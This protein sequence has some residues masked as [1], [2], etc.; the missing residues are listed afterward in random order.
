MEHYRHVTNSNKERPFVFEQ[1]DVSD[2]ST[3]RYASN[4]RDVAARLR[5][6]L[7]KAIRQETLLPKAIIFVVDDDLIKQ[8]HMDIDR[9]DLEEFYTEILGAMLSDM[10]ETVIAYK[11]KLPKKSKT[12]N[13]P[14][15]LW[16]SPP[17]NVNFYN[18][19]KRKAFSAALLSA[20]DNFAEM[21]CLTLKKIWSE[22][23]RSL[24]LKHQSRFT[25]EGF[26]DY[27][28]SIDA[29]MKFWKKPSVKYL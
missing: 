19:E 5:N 22:A 16:I 2:F 26:H 3:T 12:Y 1:Y 24:Y 23:D 21:A 14:Q 15:I 17:T 28:S 13:Y 27:W 25:P 11:D 4:I 8:V 6:L 29:G 9:E 18:N 10:H 20:V 7:Y